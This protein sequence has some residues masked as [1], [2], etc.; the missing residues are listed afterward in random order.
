MFNKYWKL[1]IVVLFS[2]PVLGQD[3]KPVQ[4]SEKVVAELRKTSQATQS[5]QADF[6]EEKQVSF[7]KETKK[8]SGVFFYKKE[9]QMRWEQTDPYLYVILIDKDKLRVKDGAKEKDMSTANRMAGRIKEMMLGM[10]NGSFD[11]NT[12]FTTACMENEESYLVVLTPVN[13]RMKNIYEKINLTFSK[14]TQ[15]LKELAFFEKNGDKS[16]MK[17]FNE[18][19]NQT[20]D[21]KLFQKL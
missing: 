11:K 13:R 6:R 7:L 9:D 17:F 19:F 21:D 10:V 3:F 16:T 1:V 4:N 18:K 20:I 12:S 2:L 8:S 14:K 5:I 15:R